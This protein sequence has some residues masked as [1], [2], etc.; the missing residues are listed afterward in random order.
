MLIKSI[1]QGKLGGPPALQ[2]VANGALSFD[3]WVGGLIAEGNGKLVDVLE[4]VYN[5]PV[6]LLNEADSMQQAGRIYEQGVKYAEK[7]EFRLCRAISHYHRSI[8]DDLGRPEMRNRRFELQH[9]ATFQFWTDVE[10]SLYSLFEVVEK[11]QLL[12]AGKAWHLTSWGR[13]ILNA[14]RIAY[15]NA[16][17]HETPRQI[18]AYALGLKELFGLSSNDEVKEKQEDVNEP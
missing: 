16:C 2:N 1:D 9:K 7:I 17:P 15:E 10:C 5:V 6:G 14:V 13:T 4:A 8:G 12:G 11:Q 3:L 18:R